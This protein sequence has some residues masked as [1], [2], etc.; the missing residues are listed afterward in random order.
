MQLEP[1]SRAPSS[2]RELTNYIVLL[3]CK[4]QLG[5]PEE[6]KREKESKQRLV[7]RKRKPC[8]NE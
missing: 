2:R 4:M 8:V 7:R 5:R 6:R 1:P 3:K